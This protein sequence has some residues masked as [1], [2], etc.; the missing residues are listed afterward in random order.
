VLFQLEIQ[1]PA[2]L[3]AAGN[4]RRQCTRWTG[5]RSCCQCE[6]MGAAC[7]PECLTACCCRDAAPAPAAWEPFE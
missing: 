1:G 3:P 7:M 4:R 6:C 5:I 2:Q